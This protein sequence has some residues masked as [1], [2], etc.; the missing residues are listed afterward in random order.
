MAKPIKEDIHTEFK[1]SFNDT[2]IESLSAFVNTKGGR[3]LVGLMDT[4]RPVK[5]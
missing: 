4:G 3:V 2:V 1:S 5:V